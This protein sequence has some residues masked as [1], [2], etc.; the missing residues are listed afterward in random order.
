MRRVRYTQASAESEESVEEDLAPC[1][2]FGQHEVH[3]SGGHL[4][5]NQSGRHEQR[6]ENA[7]EKHHAE[8]ANGEN[9]TPVNGLE[10][11]R[12]VVRVFVDV[13][14]ALDGVGA[15]TVRVENE[16]DVARNAVSVGV[17]LGVRPAIDIAV[18]VVVHANA[19]FL[20]RVPVKIVFV[21]PDARVVGLYGWVKQTGMRKSIENVGAVEVFL[22]VVAVA[23]QSYESPS[24]SIL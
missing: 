4:V 9:E 17:L 16:L 13:A 2:G 20:Q 14:V 15:T 22:P 7:D 24:L 18:S 5:S 3:R 21:D 19:P 8:F 1:N 11:I 10:R 23:V 6:H 12:L